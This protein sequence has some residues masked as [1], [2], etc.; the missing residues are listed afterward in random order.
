M[1]RMTRLL[2]A[3]G[4]SL[5]LVAAACAGNTDTNEVTV[6]A[7]S[8][9]TGVFESL[10]ES[11]EREN[12]NDSVRFSF[13]GSSELVAQVQQGVPADV[14]A[15]ADEETMA[16][17]TQADLLEG[18]PQMIALNELTIVVEA[19]NPEN[20]QGLTDLDRKDLKIVLA[21]EQVPA[22]KYSRQVLD[23]VNVMVQPKSL[24][25]DVKAVLTKV[26]L[27]EAD[28]GIVYVTD[29]QA[30][31]SAIG[32]VPIPD[33]QNVTAR[34]MIGVLK[35]APNPESAGTFFDLVLSEHGARALIQAGF[36]TP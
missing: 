22:G 30:A 28:A 35:E 13:A 20:I 11:F 5:C 27:G 23:S 24:E 12:P 19:G 1:K 25:E 9:L 26:S 16:Q 32:S 8:S 17:L 34:Y 36:R 29:V 31:G 2:A 4:M 18:Q 14:I 10:G 7:A 33:E 15:T 6:L 3:F 21:A